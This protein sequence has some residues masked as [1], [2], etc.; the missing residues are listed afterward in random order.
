M[1][2]LGAALGISICFT[3]LK[4]I[5]IMFRLG[6]VLNLVHFS[7][8]ADALER[9]SVVCVLMRRVLVNQKRWLGRMTTVVL[10]YKII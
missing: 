8:T 9:E 3:T 1:D 6:T 2:F 7:V 4:S 10:A 5:I